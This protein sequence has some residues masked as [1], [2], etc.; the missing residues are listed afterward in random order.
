[1]VG[2]TSKSEIS[3]ED[4]VPN[5]WG[6]MLPLGRSNLC[7]LVLVNLLQTLIFLRRENLNE[8]IASI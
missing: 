3:L 6:P 2:L 8:G 7:W 4:V 1:M 5:L